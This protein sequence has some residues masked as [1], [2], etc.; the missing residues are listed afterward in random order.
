M[1]SGAA[2][3]RHHWMTDG[4][5]EVMDVFKRLLSVFMGVLLIQSGCGR[6]RSGQKADDLYRRGLEASRKGQFARAEA[7]LEQASRLA[8]KRLGLCRSLA[9]VRVDLGRLDRAAKALER[10][11]SV[12][13]RSDPERYPAFLDLAGIHRRQ[14]K[15]NAAA[16]VYGQAIDEHPGKVQAYWR[17]GALYE[18]HSQWPEASDV[19]RRLLAHHPSNGVKADAFGRLARI[20][21]SSG[22][23]N[24]ALAFVHKALAVPGVPAPLGSRIEAQAAS[25]F[26]LNKESSAGLTHLKKAAILDPSNGGI[27]FS[28]ARLLRERAGCKAALPALRKALRLMPKAPDVMRL[29]ASCLGESPD[30]N[31]RERA[32]H[33]AMDAH[34]LAPADDSLTLLAAEFLVTHQEPGQAIG[35]LDR[36]SGKPAWKS[37]ARYWE[38]R[39]RA[40]QGLD[41]HMAAYHAFSA[42]VALAAVRSGQPD[43]PG[44]RVKSGQ[45]VKVGQRGQ[46]S[47][48]A[49]SGVGSNRQGGSGAGN[50]L[51][52]ALSGQAVE[53]VWSGQYRRGRD[54]LTSLLRRRKDDVSL[55]VHLAVAEAMLGRRG[56]AARILARAKRLEP[57]N[58]LVTLYRAWLSLRIGQI[59]VALNLVR[60]LVSRPGSLRIQALDLLAQAL[61]RLGRK[62]EARTILTQAFGLAGTKS[63]KAYFGK[64]LQEIGPSRHTSKIAPGGSRRPPH[65]ESGATRPKL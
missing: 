14:G 2:I 11:L 55:L 23:S 20:A 17:L 5:D 31:D 1:S 58:D 19:Y 37:N 40:L 48:V 47:P 27:W 32:Y 44:R 25:I 7:L 50:M 35:L 42:A 56:R 57:H 33:L 16:A 3:W 13:C 43:K 36:L 63:K 38:A 8:P 39:G 22:Q 49:E 24:M 52:R 41:R 60:N 54:L 64:M 26:L 15:D 10:G 4:L 46:V 29:G 51:D 45:S 18:A 34:H 59:K 62:D 53:A 61:M 30:P 21:Q 6:A 28:L 12:S 65:T 9:R